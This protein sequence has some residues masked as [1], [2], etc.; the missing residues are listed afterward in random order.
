MIIKIGRK[1]PA[2]IEIDTQRWSLLAKELA[3]VCEGKNLEDCFYASLL[4]FSNCYALSLGGERRARVIRMVHTQLLAD[5]QEAAKDEAREHWRDCAECRPNL[6]CQ[7]YIEIFKSIAD[8]TG[9]P[10][11]R[12]NS[13]GSFGISDQPGPHEN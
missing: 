11:L 8:A 13:D 12:V 5:T 2:E 6:P 7:V 9:A 3:A 10:T 4:F 1:T